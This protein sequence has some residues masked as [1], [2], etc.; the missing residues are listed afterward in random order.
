MCLTRNYLTPPEMGDAV[1]TVKVTHSGLTVSG[2]RRDIILTSLQTRVHRVTVT[3]TA[4][5]APNVIT[6]AT[7]SVAMTSP[8]VNVIS[9]LLD[10]LTL[11]RPD[12]GSAHV[13]RPARSVTRV[14][15]R[16]EVADVTVRLT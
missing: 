16:P 4:Q 1:R 6:W 3:C 15:V 12:V 7:A 10:T 5:P 2:A 8:E 9:A 11:D 13:H 14:I